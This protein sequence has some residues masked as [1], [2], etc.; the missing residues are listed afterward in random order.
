MLNAALGVGLCRLPLEP[1]LEPRAQLY[2]SM[3]ILI[4]TDEV[5]RFFYDRRLHFNI[6]NFFV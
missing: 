2:E 4:A 6:L 3:H 1:G 5:L